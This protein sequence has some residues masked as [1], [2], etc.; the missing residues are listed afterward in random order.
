MRVE[1]LYFIGCPHYEPTVELVHEVIRTLRVRAELAEIEVTDNAQAQR[2]RFLGSPTVR[3]DGADIEP[4]AA[5][6]TEYALGCRLYGTSGV[7]PRE[8]LIGAL[9]G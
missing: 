7:P 8:L 1:V 2:L 6:R 3:V 9:G 4:A 5:G